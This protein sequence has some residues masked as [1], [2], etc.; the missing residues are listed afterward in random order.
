MAENQKSV[1]DLVREI[2]EVAP[3]VGSEFEEHAGAKRAAIEAEALILE[4]ALAAAKPGLKAIVSRI[5]SAERTAWH[6]NAY[7][8]SEYDHAEKRGVRVAGVK[9]PQQIHPRDNS[10]QYE[11]EALFVM[12]DGSLAEGSY[13]GSWT[14]WQGQGSGWQMKLVSLSAVEAMEG[15]ELPEVLEGLAQALDAQLGKRAEPAKAARER[16]EKLAAIAKLAK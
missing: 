5:R 3:Q 2:S 7:T 16:A 1:Q 6:D 11:G 8:S 14:R 15:W 12:E 13:S 4:R 9:G 10:G